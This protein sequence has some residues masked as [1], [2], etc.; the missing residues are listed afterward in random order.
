MQL[1]VYQTD[2]EA[3]EAAAALA[4]ARL[5]AA[6]RAG[7]AT[8]ALPG[9]RGGRALLVALAGRPEVP[10]PRV[11]VFFT[12]DC[13]LPDGDPR[14][15][16]HVAR[17]SLLVPRGVPA[18]R[19]HPIAVADGEAAAAAAYERVLE[20]AL[21]SPPALDV[22]LLELGTA[23]EVAAVAPR[24]P[25]AR[26]VAAVAAVAPAAG[27]DGV[28]RVTLTPAA[29]R[30]ARHVVVTA[31]GTACAGALAAA[32]REPVDAITRPAQAVLPSATASWFVDRAA[33]EVLLRD[34]HPATDAQ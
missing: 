20:G 5:V 25:A 3:Y 26:S 30:A 7:R 17:S 14:R 11:D 32:L 15:T 18:D 27:G 31:T 34:A 19:I 28:G 29:L 12:D 16:L 33:A 22:V 2:A 9:G 10:W 21:G 24:S 6:A 4:A 13:C 8:V 1:E 23:G